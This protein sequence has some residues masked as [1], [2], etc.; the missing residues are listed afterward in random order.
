MPRLQV[1]V[2]RSIN[3]TEQ[4]VM[5]GATEQPE[6]VV[7]WLEEYSYSGLIIHTGFSVLS[8]DLLLA[9]L[10]SASEGVVVCAATQALLPNIFSNKKLEI[11]HGNT[12][13]GYAL[14]SEIDTWF[15]LLKSVAVKCRDNESL[16]L[17]GP[18]SVIAELNEKREELCNTFKEAFVGRGDL[19]RE[20][21][22]VSI[23]NL[24]D[25]RSKWANI[26]P[27]HIH[28]I[29]S[30]IYSY[31][32]DTFNR[33]LSENA[34]LKKEQTRREGI[35][36]LVSYLPPWAAGIP[37]EPV[38]TYNAFRAEN[39]TSLYDLE[40][41][42]PVKLL[43][44]PNLG[45]NSIK[46]L[47]EYLRNFKVPIPP[48]SEIKRDSDSGKNEKLCDIFK[49]AFVAR[50]DLVQ[51]LVESSVYT[52]TDFRNKWTNIDAQ[53]I[54]DIAITLLDYGI[55]KFKRDCLENTN[56]KTE[57]VQREGVIK[58]VSFLPPW[59]AN[60]P[61]E[62]VRTYNALRAENYDSLY[63]LEQMHSI[64]LIQIPNIGRNS[65]K[66]LYEYLI[67]FRVPFPP[68]G[69]VKG[70]SR[71]KQKSEDES[72]TT[73]QKT[74][75]SYL[76]L[77]SAP[78]LADVIETLIND[79]LDRS[80]DERSARELGMLK[81]RFTGETLESIAETQALTR[82]RI[83]QL[84]DKALRY[85]VRVCRL[86]APGSNVNSDLLWVMK[87]LHS[88]DDCS[89][90]DFSNFVRIFSGTEAFE[91]G[92]SQRRMLEKLVP[93]QNVTL[94]PFK[95]SS[96]DVILPLD[97]NYSEDFQEALESEMLSITESIHGMK[98][99]EA[100]N[101]AKNHLLGLVD[102]QFF[103][104]LIAKEIVY[105]RSSIDE[106]TKTINNTP[107]R[108][109]SRQ[110]I[111]EIVSILRRNGEPMHGIDDIYPEMPAVYKDAVGNRRVISQ[112]NEYQEQCPGESAD[113]IFTMGRGRYA[114][115]EHFRIS[116]EDGGKCANFIDAYLAEN[117]ARQFTDLELFN[118]LKEKGIVTWQADHVDQ[119][120]IVSVI[121][122]R[123]RPENVRYFGRF[124]WGK[125]KWTDKVDTSNRFQVNQLI[126]ELIKDKGQP[127][128]KYYI[129]EHIAST[130]GRG[131][132]A[133]YHEKNGLIRL[134]A[135]GKN[136]LYWHESLDPVPFNSEQSQILR[137]EVLNLLTNTFD[138]GIY[139]SGLKADI[140]HNSDII[141][142]F[143]SAQFLALLLRM[144]EVRVKKDAFN[145]I[146]VS[147]EK[148]KVDA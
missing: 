106:D 97:K 129:D 36:K 137:D 49:E 91:V 67:N 94:V 128:P 60:I 8:R 148:G 119:H 81:R 103:S 47:Y 56:F 22:A 39:Y 104:S 54:H 109:T 5:V 51:A 124:V 130:R 126:E 61:T 82:E 6:Q 140:V 66:S 85:M 93:E 15:F 83:R 20:L 45:S 64:K 110:A 48:L 41:E 11:C 42:S 77:D 100:E 146:I 127:V 18:N 141:N 125:G 32:T 38:R 12:D 138:T 59:A 71:R 96:K 14:L 62:P 43:Q 33:Y 121:L 10:P 52:L 3:Q 1:R 35:I 2:Y 25:F 13:D 118:V 46:L 139:M 136:S 21:V 98:L 53:H 102:S 57:Q 107:N 74:N 24:K 63:D 132:T 133:Q 89:H 111:A 80:V 147:L 135:S 37:M 122:M 87:D 120:R 44:I 65:V 55:K 116:D 95:L 115:W 101:Y 143:N 7:S 92:A 112:I 68:L 40:N 50:D 142:Q 4:W 72:N 84:T 9:L 134:T 105:Y 26:D 144:P 27:E 75:L 113:Y 99:D 131:V 108:M 90:A 17:V 76:N 23:Y 31:G 58:L 88:W 78:R 19:I 34:S 29:G 114:L 145:K 86:M 79:E 123:Y 73:K 70:D 30:M 117:E 28:E 16:R 69:E